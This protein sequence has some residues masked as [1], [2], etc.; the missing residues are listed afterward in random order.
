MIK[1]A[2]RSST[3]FL[4][5]SQRFWGYREAWSAGIRTLRGLCSG[6]SPRDVGDTI[7]FLCLAK[8]ISETLQRTGTCDESKQFFQDLDRWQN[9]FN[10]EADRDSYRDA[11]YSM[12]GVMLDENFSSQGQVDASVLIHFQGLASTLVTQGSKLPGFNA[13][14]DTGLGSSQKGWLL[15]NGIIPSRTDPSDI[16]PDLRCSLGSGVQP[17][18]IIHPRAPDSAVCTTRKALRQ[19]LETDVSSA[20]I[21][22]M[23]ILL[24]AGAIFAIVVVFLQ[25]LSLSRTPLI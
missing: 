23:A 3:Q 25:C 17:Q 21:E 12:W 18:K 24:M 5:L 2:Q 11:I 8:A 7:A 22:P 19:E 20:P 6:E 10:S 15:R 16:T 1:A 4:E 9:L 14:N 13:L